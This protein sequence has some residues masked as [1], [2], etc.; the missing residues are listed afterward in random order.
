MELDAQM[1]EKN[2]KNQVFE[3]PYNFKTILNFWF[4]NQTTDL[5]PSANL[6]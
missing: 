2:A 4:K 3:K 5:K 6:C 1:Y